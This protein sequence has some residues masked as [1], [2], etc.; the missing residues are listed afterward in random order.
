[1]IDAAP[2]SPPDLPADPPSVLIRDAEPED[3][4]FIA[5]HYNHYVLTTAVSMETEAVDSAEIARRMADVRDG[6]LPWIVLEEHGRLLGWAY[7]TKWRARPG[8]RHAVETTVY[9]APAQGA[10]GHG[11]RLYGALL[12]RLRGRFHCAIGGIAL[13]NPAS[14]ALHER[15][16]FRQVAHFA[17]VGHKFGAWI[18]VGYWQRML[19]A[20]PADQPAAEP[21]PPISR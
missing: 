21:Q 16:G 9:L 11:T 10:R 1:M 15:L 7:A 13:P 17:E 14:V 8:Y 2:V 20:A 18:D 4:G 5:S 3:A 19:D 12:E 6:G